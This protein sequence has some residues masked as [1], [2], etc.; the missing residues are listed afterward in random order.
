MKTLLDWTLL[1]DQ[2]QSWPIDF[3]KQMQYWHNQAIES[4][5]Q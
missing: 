1:T 5:K 4:Q 3:T 2:K